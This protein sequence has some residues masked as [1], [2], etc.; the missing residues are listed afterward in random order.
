MSTNSFPIDV[1]FQGA[2]GKSTVLF[3]DQALKGLAK[4]GVNLDGD[5]RGKKYLF[6]VDLHR[7]HFE[8]LSNPYLYFYGVWSPYDL[9]VGLQREKFSAGRLTSLGVVQLPHITSERTVR[10]TWVVENNFADRILGLNFQHGLSVRSEKALSR[11][12]ERFPLQAQF[13][14]I[15]ATI[16]FLAFGTIAFSFAAT[17]KGYLDIWAFATFCMTMALFIWAQTPVF[18]D[19]FLDNARMLVTI[20]ALVASGSILAATVLT[21]GY[22]RLEGRHWRIGSSI[23]ALKKTSVESLN[24]LSDLLTHPFRMTLFATFTL[25]TVIVAS[26]WPMT[27][28]LELPYATAAI[29]TRLSYVL[30][31]SQTLA[32]FFGFRSLFQTRA[33]FL[34]SGLIAQAKMLNRRFALSIIFAISMGLMLAVYLTGLGAVSLEAGT[35][36]IL[37]AAIFPAL[38]MLLMF[39]WMVASA[40]RFYARFSPRLGQAD[41]EVMAFGAEALNKRYCATLFVF[42]MAGMKKLNQLRVQSQANEQAVDDLI[43]KVEHDLGDLVQKGRVTFRYKSNGDEFIF[44]MWAKDAD[45]ARRQFADIMSAWHAQGAGLMAS[46][47]AHMQAAGL[48]GVADDFDMH[49]LACT[50]TDVKITVK[51]GIETPTAAPD[52]IDARFTRLS[53]LFKPSRWNRVAVFADDATLWLAKNNFGAK[54]ESDDGEIGFLQLTDA[55]HSDRGAA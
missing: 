52:F 32:F 19:G 47:R 26:F 29:N 55:V 30:A 23:S 14:R 10:V 22:F 31:A 15:V 51:G 33:H 34:R 28:Q 8:K 50:M 40:Q 44:A 5:L 21:L 38:A 18:Y 9:Y 4:S 2:H 24:K 46:W 41:Q 16:A 42:D 27:T 54:F 13:P 37:I 7:E 43:S 6:F 11:S 49:V 39:F 35:D 53:A 1:R 48:G 3:R 12:L 25:C 17:A 36:V 45:D 20:R